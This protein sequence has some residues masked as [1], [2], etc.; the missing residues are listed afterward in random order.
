MNMNNLNELY[1]EFVDNILNNKSNNLFNIHSDIVTKY[2]LHD[3]FKVDESKFNDIEQ[4]IWKI[5]GKFNNISLYTHEQL[6]DDV[7]SFFENEFKYYIT[8]A[9]NKHKILL[10]FSDLSED[11]F[12]KDPTIYYINHFL[13]SIHYE[14]SYLSYYIFELID[15]DYATDVRKDRRKG[16]GGSQEFFTPFSIVQKMCDKILDDAVVFLFLYIVD[17]EEQR[18]T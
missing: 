8:E 16:K 12:V 11:D 1:K 6:Y 18:R 13:K 15:H 7:K 4:K 14:R 10:L 9:I 3:P 17:Y 2:N 5:F